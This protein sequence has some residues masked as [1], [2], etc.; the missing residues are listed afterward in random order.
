M[1]RDIESRLAKLEAQAAPLRFVVGGDQEE[2]ERKRN[3]L[4]P[5]DDAVLIVTGVRRAEGWQ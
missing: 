4:G 5:G 3:A 1:T 2:C